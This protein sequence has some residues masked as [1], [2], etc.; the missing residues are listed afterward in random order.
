[1]DLPSHPHVLIYLTP[2]CPYCR[3]AIALLREKN[4]EFAA[5]DVSGDQTAR[6]W[7]LEQSGQ[8]TV[9]QIFIGGRS[10]GGCDELYALERRDELDGLLA[11]SSTETSRP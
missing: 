6:H 11:A 4:V 3:R 2:W 10:I 9:P 8:R 7:L 1:M 5:F